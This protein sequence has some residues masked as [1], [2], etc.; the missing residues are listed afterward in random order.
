M[1]G[2]LRHKID[3]VT[4]NTLQDA[5]GAQ[6]LAAS[7]IYAN[8][9]ATVQAL[10]GQEKFAAHEFVSQV[11]HQIIIRYIG[12]APSWQPDNPYPQCFLIKDSNGNLQR[13][14]TYGTS[15]AQA[16]TAWA[17]R[18]GDITTETTGVQWKCCG[19]APTVSGV[20][21]GMMV[22]FGTRTF[23]VEAVLNVDERTKMLI[24]MCIEINNSLQQ[25][26]TPSALS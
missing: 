12:A 14:I 20:N 9:W 10:S 2:R 26:A 7:T 18:P 19:P 11:T 15:A 22:W 17:S 6:S 13:C 3:I 24:L 4:V 21:A 25:Q 8:V 1:A 5:N 16:P 23:Q